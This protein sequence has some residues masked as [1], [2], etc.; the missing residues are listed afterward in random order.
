VDNKLL[1]LLI[2]LCLRENKIATE[3]VESY[4][5]FNNPLLFAYFNNK[6]FGLFGEEQFEITLLD[7]TC[8][9]RIESSEIKLLKIKHPVLNGT[10]KDNEKPIEYSKIIIKETIN[11]YFYPILKNAISYIKSSSPEH[12]EIIEK[13]CQAV[14]LFFTPPSNTNSFATINA[15]GMAFLNVYQQE[16]YDEVFFVDDLSH[17]T[18]HI[19]MN[20]FWFDRKKHFI[21]GENNAIKDIVKDPKEY[22]SF[23]IL[24][25]ALYTYYA[26]I[27]CLEDCIDNN[28]FNSSQELEASARIVFYLK[29][30]VSDLAK[31][32]LVCK[33]FGGI[34]NV[35]HQE[36]KHLYYKIKEKYVS[37]FERW[38]N[39]INQFNFQKQP[40]NFTFS[41]FK[42][43]N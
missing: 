35:L 40:Y 22:R 27:L 13:H 34:D 21:I 39:E 23:F 28:L 41:I 14:C 43:N 15:H 42:Q 8:Y 16:E 4:E 5:S 24:Y 3:N 6:K 11:D 30:Y 38:K 1:E 9:Q 37:S 33:H 31:F 20:S 25:H 10:F 19:I 7:Q 12:Y 36:N 18:G 32:E 2:T 26:T 17:Q 29:K